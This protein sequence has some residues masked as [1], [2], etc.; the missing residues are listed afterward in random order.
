[1][2]SHARCAESIYWGAARLTGIHRPIYNLAT[3][4]RNVGLFR[5]HVEGD[6]YFWG[7]LCRQQVKYC[8]N[9]IYP[10]I[11]TLKQCPMMPYADPDRPF[12]NYWYASSAG[13]D[14]TAF[15]ELI[16]EEYQDRL[17]AEG[18]ACI[19]YTHFASGFS[20]AHGVDSQFRRLIERL[21]RKNGWFVPVAT[22]LDYLL[23]QR[24]RAEITPRE[25]RGLE[26]RWLRYK[27][28]SGTH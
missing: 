27:L 7:D 3:R 26:R 9:F 28:F 2:A 19:V 25:R 21:S 20:N 10:D 24:S 4:F 8:R 22:L 16:G 12:V 6:R 17:E 1:M 18:G 5:G 23:S 14:V 15:V 11:N 13:H